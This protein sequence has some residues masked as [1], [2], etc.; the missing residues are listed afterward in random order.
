MLQVVV[1]IEQGFLW[2]Y[3]GFYVS[4]KGFF[5]ENRNLAVTNQIARFVTSMI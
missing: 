1:E 3:K 4:Y 2:S 5:M